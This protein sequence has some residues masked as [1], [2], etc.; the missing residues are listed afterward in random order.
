MEGRIEQKLHGELA[1]VVFDAAASSI[2]MSNLDSNVARDVE[3]WVH[4]GPRW[5]AERWPT[6]AVFVVDHTPKEGKEPTGTKR[7]SDTADAVYYVESKSRIS[8]DQHGASWVSVKKDRQG[9]LPYELL[10]VFEG[11]GG[12]PWSIRPPKPGEA[13]SSASKVSEED[14]RAQIKAVIEAGRPNRTKMDALKKQIGG[15]STETSKRVA[16]MTAEGILDYKQGF[17]IA[18][19]QR[20][21]D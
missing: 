11:G 20:F 13:G 6:A 5:I 7:K 15:S 3:S 10:F 21:D 14:K 8:R 12:E 9:F 2:M 17:G 16:A 1:V 19:G 18:P 4:H